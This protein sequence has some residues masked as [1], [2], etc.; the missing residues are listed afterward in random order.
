MIITLL[1]LYCSSQ[2]VKQG[3]YENIS[4]LVLKCTKPQIIYNNIYYHCCTFGKKAAFAAEQ[5]ALQ[6]LFSAWN[7]KVNV[8]GALIFLRLSNTWKGEAIIK[9]T[10]KVWH[11]FFFFSFFFFCRLDQELDFIMAQQ[12]E[13]EEMLKP[14]EDAVKDGNTGGRQLQQADKERDV[15]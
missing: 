12:K 4:G 11:V 1:F 7:A 13:L 2:G 10:V 15:T 9:N 5:S 3:V 8:S 6:L 14:L